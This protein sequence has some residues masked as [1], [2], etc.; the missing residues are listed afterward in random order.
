MARA[1]LGCGMR[2]A[3]L[4]LAVSALLSISCG[5]AVAPVPATPPP[6]ASAPI[7]AAAPS[8]LDEPLPFDARVRK[9]VLPSG[10]TYYVLPHQK[11]EHRAQLWLAVNAGSVLEDDD[12]RGLAHFVEHM[13]FNGTRRFPKQALVDL[14]EKSGVA[15]GADLNAYTSFDETV[16]TLTGPHRQARAPRARGRHPPRLGGRR[17]VRPR[18]GREGARR[19]ARGVAARPRR[20]HA[21]LRQAGARPL[22]R[23]EV[24][25]AAHHRQ[26]RDHHAARPRD[27]LVRFYKD[28]YRP[29][30]M[31]VIAVGDFAPDEME[32]KIKAE[33]ASLPP[34]SRPATAPR[35]GRPGARRAA[36]LDRDRPRGRPRPA[37]PSDARCRT[38][39]SRPCATTG[40]RSPSASS[41]RMLNA[42]L[43]EIRR[44][45]NAPFLYAGLAARAASSGRRMRSR[46]RR[47]GEG[48]RRRGGVRR[49]PRG[50][51]PRRAARLHR[52]GA[53]AGE[54]R[55]APLVRAGPSRSA[56]P[57]TARSSRARSS[58]TSSPTRRCP[59]RRRSS[60]SPP[61]SSCHVSRSRS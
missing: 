51:A 32:A 40:A 60:R 12:Q 58:A 5:P 13:G 54:E 38:A 26:A 17:D 41:T 14:L 21:P 45:P 46:S 29:D 11:P 31:A 24:R 7:V 6:V 9:G 23:V 36:R 1:T 28:W 20:R 8:V 3:A 56:T 35:G 2:A 42:R 50:D 30:L 53:R 22:P 61:S 55:R 59:A 27:T 39:R 4:V 47:R 52:V 19:R 43:D 37:C 34:A 49:A 33:F 44:K 15:F 18:R 25:R 48:G 57:R 16:Y 10:L